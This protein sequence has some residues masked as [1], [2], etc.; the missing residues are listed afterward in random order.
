MKSKR[1]DR[2]LTRYQTGKRRVVVA[3]RERRAPRCQL[4]RCLK[5]KAVRWPLRTSAVCSDDSFENM[6]APAETE[7]FLFPYLHDEDQS[8]ARAYGAACTPDF[9]GFDAQGACNT[10]DDWMCRAAAS[11]GAIHGLFDQMEIHLTP[12]YQKFTR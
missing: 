12:R 5:A 9:F 6:K 11:S 7:G 10:V 8:V 4:L 2:R 3:L 1:V